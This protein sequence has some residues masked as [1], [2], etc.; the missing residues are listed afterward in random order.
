MQRIAG[1]CVLCLS[2]AIASG[3]ATAA[4]V[5]TRPSPPQ[6]IA[7]PGV[8]PAPETP[9]TAAD[10]QAVRDST[11]RFLEA[12]DHGDFDA[13]R[14]MLMSFNSSYATPEDRE[15][16]VGFNQGESGEPVRAIQRITWYDNV[17]GAPEGRYAVVHV[18]GTYA[19]EGFYCGSVTWLRQADGTWLAARNSINVMASKYAH[20]MRESAR[21]AARA[22]IACIE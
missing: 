20:K 15:R 14:R 6:R 5:E 11:L 18:R 2:L 17:E 1:M 9:P 8:P 3:I 12:L 4:Q 19:G 13:V 22:Q 7:L 16:R 21:V 10:E